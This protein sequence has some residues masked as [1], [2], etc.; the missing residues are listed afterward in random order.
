MSPGCRLL[1]VGYVAA[2]QL[3]LLVV[4]VLAGCS[5]RAA[6]RYSDAFIFFQLP[7]GLIA[8]SVMTTMTPELAS[9]AARGR[10]PGAR[11]PVRVGAC[12]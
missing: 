10:L 2:N 9:A 12:A 1:D 8:V 7:H 11:G 6:K 5:G 4:Y 3:A